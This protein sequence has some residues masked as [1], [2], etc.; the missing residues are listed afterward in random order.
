MAASAPVQWRPWRGR[1]GR[2]LLLAMDSREREEGRHGREEG[3]CA[4]N[5]EESCA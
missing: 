5:R 4:M 3:S 2:C 1:Q